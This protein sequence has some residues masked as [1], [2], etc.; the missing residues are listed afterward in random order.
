MD[1]Q[2]ADTPR[3]DPHPLRRAIA[4]IRT[5]ISSA[6]GVSAADREATIGAMLERGA[7]ESAGYW[8]QLL[9]AMGIASLGLVLGSTAVVIGAMLISPLMGPI[10][11]LGMGLAIGSP[12]LVLRSF[13]RTVASIAVVVSS[14]ALLTLA[15][16]FYEVTPEIAARTAPTL[17][18]LTV[19]IFCAIA[20]A[21]TTVRPGSGTT[22]TAAGTAI[23]I[24]L[25]PPLCVVGY[26]L[27]TR[28]W[29]ISSGAALLFTANFCAILLF[30]VLCFLLLGYSAVSVA[31]LER[32]ELERKEQ[33]VIRR[34]ASMLKLVFG[35]KYGLWLRVV[36]PLVL[37][38]AVYL[39]LSAALAE[40]SWQVRVRGAIQRML[41]TLPQDTVRSN[42]SVERRR[43]SV[44]LVTLGSGDEAAALEREL[45]SKIAQAAGVTPKV[46]VIAVPDSSALQAVA[47]SIKASA[48]P[49][50]VVHK[51]PDATLLRASIDGALSRAWPE[52][53]GTLLLF[54]LEF[55][56]DAPM[57]VEAIH[58]GPPLGPAGAALLGD[59]LSRELGATVAVRDRAVAPE[60]ITAPPEDGIKWLSATI[61]ELAMLD[62]VASLHG[63]VEV[64]AATRF[65][66]IRDAEAIAAT[67]RTS[68]AYTTGRLDVRAGP[69]WKAVL[70][71]SPCAAPETAAA[72]GG[73]PSDAGSAAPR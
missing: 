35:S 29:S 49:V 15:L 14:A 4:A 22:A 11:E 34:V 25:V 62:A 57:V 68:P 9:L 21:Y 53:A 47:A 65:K 7:K 12:L 33:G 70:S 63:C 13:T 1:E 10:V 3:P 48:A 37:F 27:G 46:S 8:L 51:E 64:P 18:D 24:A 5:R 60:P 71:I 72:D 67:I 52:E 45:S 40:V 41:D 32:A 38:G 58:L 42:I 43:V 6:F 73:A 66:P 56:K 50:E 16:P 31:A 19:A 59:A 26:G 28:S 17:L 55:P 44:R 39:P 30:A 23:G 20:A 69:R 54:R 2:S 36:M 61:T